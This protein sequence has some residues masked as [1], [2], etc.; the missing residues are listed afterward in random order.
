MLI[1]LDFDGVL[2]GSNPQRTRI[3]W[4]Q[5]PVFAEFFGQDEWAHTEFVVSST[6]RIGRSLAQLREPFPACLRPR[7]IGTTPPLHHPIHAL[8]GCREREILCWLND[9]CQTQRNWAALDD[10]AWYF[11]DHRHRLFLCAG[12]YG[13]READ[14]PFLAQ[15]LRGL[16]EPHQR[17][18]FHAKQ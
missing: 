3:L 6:W 16:R 2:H 5:M 14:L 4:Q 7:I 13:L 18:S 12:Q 11:R 1:F 9:F 10:T 15:H 8:H 17:A